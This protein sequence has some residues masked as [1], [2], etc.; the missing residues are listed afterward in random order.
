MSLYGTPSASASIGAAVHHVP[1]FNGELWF[2]SASGDDANT[3]TEPHDPF[4]TIG[5]AISEAA[6]GD[7]ISVKAGTYT[8]TGIDVSKAGME[9]WF[10][11]GVTLAPAS[12]T[13]LL[14]SG[15]ANRIRGL[16][17]ISPAAGQTGLRITTTICSVEDVRVAGGATGFLIEGVGN[18]LTHCRSATPSATG[19]DIKAGQNKLDRC[20]TVGSGGSTVGYSVS[21]SSDYGLLLDCTSAGHGTAGYKIAAGSSAWTL[22]GCSS[23]AGD[24]RWVDEGGVNVWSGFTFDDELAHSVTFDGSG[25]AFI[26]L[27]KIT[28]TVKINFIFGHVETALHADVDRIYIDLWDGTNAVEVTDN[29][30]TDTSS[31]GVGSVFVKTEKATIAITKLESDQCRVEENTNYRRPHVPFIAVQKQSTDTWIRLHYDGTG[32][33]GAMHWHIRWEPLTDDGFVEVV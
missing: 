28:G 20:A 22:L 8:E 5:H 33:S 2:V 4:L 15:G 19:F 1:K 3:G 17:V 26:N 18:T 24:G 30:G 27:F 11:I 23:G 6:A 16:L 14:V 9:L 21:G 13:G 10:E 31:A 7:A 32:T 12:G 25:P 29:G